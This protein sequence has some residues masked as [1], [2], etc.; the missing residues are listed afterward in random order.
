[1][2]ILLLVYPTVGVPGIADDSKPSVYLPLNPTYVPADFQPMVDLPTH[3]PWI[4][5]FHE[6]VKHTSFAKAVKVAHETRRAFS[7]QES[8]PELNITHNFH[9]SIHGVA[10]SGMTKE[11]LENIPGVEHVYP[12]LTVYANEYSWGVDRIDQASGTDNSYSPTYNGTG[13]DVYVIDTG[14]DTTHIEFE[15]IGM[16]RTVENIYNAYGDCCVSNTDG[17]GH[18]THV[19]GEYAYVCA[20]RW[21]T[22]VVCFRGLLFDTTTCM[23]AIFSFFFIHLPN[24]YRRRQHHWRGKRSERL[25]NERPQ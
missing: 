15:D 6:S 1:L 17:Q 25:R 11:D 2:G 9:L 13:V 22:I 8:I 14:L 10:L 23:Y 12:D 18:G 4:V 16:N 24:R 20:V 5:R 19:S 21:Q 3:G 7:S